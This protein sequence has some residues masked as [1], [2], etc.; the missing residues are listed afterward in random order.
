MGYT[1]G[2]WKVDIRVGIACVYADNEEDWRCL[3]G[4]RDRCIYWAHG[5][6]VLN[7][8]DEP[9]SHWEVNPE[10]IANAHL[11]AA[12]PAMHEALTMAKEVMEI[13]EVSYAMKG[14]V[15]T[16]PYQAIVAALAKAE[17]KEI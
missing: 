1:K 2:E 3:D 12:A 13:S 15:G 10:Y 9:F 14:Q 17:G 16:E 4:L 5:E 8:D 11:I 7:N 6:W